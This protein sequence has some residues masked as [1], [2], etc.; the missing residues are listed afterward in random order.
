[1][2]ISFE[3]IGMSEIEEF[4][5]TL[6]DEIDNLKSDKFVLDFED[7]DKICL[8]GVQVLISFAKHCKE[9]NIELDSINIHSNQLVDAFN[10]YGLNQ[11]LGIEND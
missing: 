2:R 11:I 10:T 9:S 5:K 1:M 4:H 6:I 3:E 8:S 7:V